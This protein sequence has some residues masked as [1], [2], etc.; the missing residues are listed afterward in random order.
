MWG[1]EGGDPDPRGG[2]MF[3]LIPLMVLVL[4]FAAC[5]SDPTPNGDGGGVDLTAP[6]DARGDSS[7]PSDGATP[8]DPGA[9]CSSDRACDDGNPCTTERCIMPGNLR[10]AR[11]E[12][13]VNEMACSAGQVCDSRRGCSAGRACATDGDCRDEDPCT[14]MERCDPASRTCRHSTLDGDRDGYPPTSCGGRDCDDNDPQRRPGVLDRC[15]RVDDNCNGQADEGMNLCGRGMSCQNGECLCA[16]VPASQMRRGEIQLCGDNTSPSQNICTDVRTDNAHCG[17]LCGPCLGGSTCQMGRCVCGDPSRTYCSDRTCSDLRTDPRNCGVCR[18]E[19]PFDAIGCV[20]GVCQCPPGAPLCTRDGVSICFNPA[21]HQEDDNRCGSCGNMCPSGSRC[22]GGRCN[23]TYP[24]NVVCGDV[25]TSLQTD[26]LNCG[27]CGHRCG[28][29]Q[30][31]R[32]GM[33]I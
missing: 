11:C 31:C 1:A 30:E 25:C 15:N 12:V 9:A 20:N 8:S 10:D 7:S 16:L 13:M 5:G 6:T 26:I 27:A 14:V 21:N 19:C 17:E 29:V 32:K 18:N 28:D 22:M 2:P 4:V 23:C 24:G 33:C 3:H